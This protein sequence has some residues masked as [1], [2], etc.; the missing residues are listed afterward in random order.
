MLGYPE[1]IQAIDEHLQAEGRAP[2]KQGDDLDLTTY[3][4]TFG[5]LVGIPKGRTVTV[6][7]RLTQEKIEPTFRMR[8]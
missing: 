1:T 7:N 8:R 4:L 5:L 2:L 3:Y 6:Y